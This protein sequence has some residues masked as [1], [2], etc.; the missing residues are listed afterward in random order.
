MIILG[1]TG[2]KENG[3]STVCD[4][5]RDKLKERG[6][7]VFR[8]NFKDPLVSVALSLGWNGIKDEKGR[9]GLQLL[10]TDVVRECFDQ[11][12]WIK[13]WKKSV[14]TM[15]TEKEGSD[16]VI[17]ADDVRFENEAQAVKSLGG[18]IIYIESP[19]KNTSIDT[20]KSEAGIPISYI[21]RSFMK[22]QVG[23]EY[24]EQIAND[25]IVDFIDS[26]FK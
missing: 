5:I 24:L 7:W 3:K 4:M 17:L 2:K 25:V 16:L 13:A 19:A 11:D 18:K 15:T 6:M 21:D 10:G 9:R 26:Q 12:H 1:F 22:V 23:L 14:Q 8:M 20:H